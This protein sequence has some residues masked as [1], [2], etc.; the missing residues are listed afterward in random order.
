M[1]ES[2]LGMT[3]FYVILPTALMIITLYLALRNT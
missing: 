3:F 2:I 1:M